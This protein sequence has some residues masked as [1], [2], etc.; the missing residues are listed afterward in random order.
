MS[1]KILIVDDDPEIRT[2]LTRYLTGEGLT[3]RAVENGVAMRRL[4]ERE[5][6][7]VLILDIMLPGEDGLSL[8]ARLRAD[9][10][11]LPI[12]MLTAKGQDIDR[13]IGIELGAD[14]YVAKPFNPRELYARIK[15]LLRRQAYAKIPGTPELTEEM[16]LVGSY[17]LDSRQRAL[18]KDDLTVAL[19]TGEFALLTAL[20]SHPMKAQSRERLLEQSRS[21]DNDVSDRSIDVQI[22][23]LRKIIEDNPADP[24]YIQTVWGFGY[25]FVPTGEKR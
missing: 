17:K 16:T 20:V 11:F 22:R 25:V 24:K 19:T 4:L 10:F 1:E 8:C 21:R 2:L 9:G 3:V 23:R 7:D 18:L 5:A 15:S 6:F 13:I 14:D 12:L